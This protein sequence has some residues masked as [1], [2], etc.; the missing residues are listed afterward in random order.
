MSPVSSGLLRLNIVT[1]RH[2]TTSQT[3][4]QHATELGG[5][6]HSLLW[7]VT[8]CLRIVDVHHTVPG[9]WDMRRFSTSKRL[10]LVI[11]WRSRLVR[12]A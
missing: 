10:Q 4:E 1:A 5:S 12:K 2:N 3:T 8:S 7:T 11:S 9:K 6:S